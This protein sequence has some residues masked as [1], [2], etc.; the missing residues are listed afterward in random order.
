MKTMVLALATVKI[1]RE[2]ANALFTREKLN[3]PLI[4]YVGS[5]RTCIGYSHLPHYERN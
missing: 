2:E 3:A 1:M 5:A 4:D